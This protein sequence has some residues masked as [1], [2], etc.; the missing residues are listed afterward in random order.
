MKK[1]F[2]IQ[3]SN[4]CNIFLVSVFVL[5][6]YSV[7]LTWYNFYLLIFVNF[8][9][10]YILIKVIYIPESF[11][12][13]LVF[14]TFFDKKKITFVNFKS[15]YH[16]LKSLFCSQNPGSNDSIKD[17]CYLY[18]NKSQSKIYILP[19][20]LLEEIFL[21]GPELHKQHNPENK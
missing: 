16:K 14:I 4:I 2:K 10:V 12:T 20:H 11:N 15:H 9:L 3:I 13:I 7:L 5:I 18:K 6:S 1:T 17:F 8:D 19:F 21:A